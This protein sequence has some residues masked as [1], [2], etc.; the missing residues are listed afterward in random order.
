M[1]L[2]EVP[3]ECKDCIFEDNLHKC[4]SFCVVPEPCRACKNMSI[5][6]YIPIDKDDV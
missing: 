1:E 5:S 4:L 6:Q 2:F 3:K